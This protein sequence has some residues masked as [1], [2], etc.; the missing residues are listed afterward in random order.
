VGP[1]YQ[2]SADSAIVAAGKPVGGMTC[3]ANG[4]TFAVHVEL[5][6]NRKVI[7]VPRGIGVSPH[8]CRYPLRTE[9][10]TGVVRVDSARPR[11]LRDLFTVWGRRL[12]RTR[13][14]SFS[15]RVSVFV[16]GR[17]FRGDPGAVP[18]TRHLQIVVEVG[19]Y[20]SPHPRY[21]FPKGSG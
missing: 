18:L 14:L 21:V 16:N 17:R 8:R 1:R 13:L 3:R 2:P 15:G 10:P 20:V 5:F 12:G 4:R 9:T 7:V 11:T 6:A 19:G